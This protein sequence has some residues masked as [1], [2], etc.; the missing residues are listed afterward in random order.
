MGHFF[1]K[2]A[3]KEDFKQMEDL[4]HGRM[5]Y[6]LNELAEVKREIQICKAICRGNEQFANKRKYARTVRIVTPTDGE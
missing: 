6:M 2:P 3:T 5:L 1:A 4:L